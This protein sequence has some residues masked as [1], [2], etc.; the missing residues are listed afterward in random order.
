MTDEFGLIFHHLGLAVPDS[1][2]AEL[3]L[4][5]QGYNAG[6]TVS[7]PLQIADLTM[8][9]H[10]SAPDIEVICPAD[11]TKGPVAEIL[12]VRPEG[13]V[14]HLCYTT[15]DLNDSIDRMEQSGLRPF[16]VSPAKP[17]VLFGGER[18]SFFMILGVGLI[19]IIEGTGV[20]V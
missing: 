12:A 5:G 4:R 3:F 19:E 16:E 18:V 15:N 11:Q 20:C 1:T 14:Y 8:W 2:A 10:P 9:R 6:K 13:L 17:A 7:D